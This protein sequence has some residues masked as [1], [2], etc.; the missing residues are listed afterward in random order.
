MLHMI[1]RPAQC[2]SRALSFSRKFALIFL[3]AVVPSL[4]LLALGI[5]EDYQNIQRDE[6]ELAGLR[7]V[8][9]LAPL[10]APAAMHRGLTGRALTGDSFLAPDIGKAEIM[11]DELLQKLAIDI[12]AAF[13][14]LRERTDRLMGKWLLAKAWQGKPPEQNFEA[15]NDFIAEAIEL[16]HFEGG[17]SR[18]LLDPDARGYFQIVTII[19]QLPQLRELVA[20]SRGCIAQINMANSD[21]GVLL[22]RTDARLYRATLVAQ[23]IDSDLALLTQDAPEIA[24]QIGAQW[25][26]VREVIHNVHTAFTAA[27]KEPARISEGKADYF[28]QF[29]LVLDN[30]DKFQASQLK[31]LREDILGRRI[32]SER[33]YVVLKAMLSLM[34]VLV[35]SW[36]IAGFALDITGRVIRL[37]TG[38]ERFGHGDFSIRLGVAGTDELSSVAQGLNRMADDLSEV[39]AAVQSDATELLRASESIGIGSAQVAQSSEEQATAAEAMASA[40]EE[41]T[42]SISQISE[43]AREANDLAEQAGQAAS[44]GGEVIDATVAR[45]RNISTTVDGASESVAQLGGHATQIS[46]I[47]G[48]IKEIADQTNLLALNAAIEAARAGESGRGFAVVADEV[49]K[50]AERTAASTKQITEMITSIQSGSRSAVDNMSR[51]VDEVHAGVGFAEQAGQAIAQIKQTSVQVVDIATAIS[52][53]LR[54]QSATTNDVAGRVENIA[55][56]SEEN[57]SAAASSAGV[58]VQL[59]GMAIGLAQR[60]ATFKFASASSAPSTPAPRQSSY[61]AQATQQLSFEGGTL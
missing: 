35:I 31:I 47:V 52:Q 43:R 59:R 14:S 19:D 32:A 29:T 6:A 53:S 58:A 50:L 5:H 54:E 28:K 27:I 13:P 37:K 41:L 3:L 7:G 1:I 34:L 45:V 10:F 60:V 8:E 48:V 25:Q 55:R 46:G 49:R 33:H 24:G 2:L 16:L 23:R 61:M 38:V 40:V 57:S 36:L 18:L 11:V 20:Q 44:N 21:I 39:L 17:E 15:H 12:P 56:M 30:M 22:G 4:M 51:G 26:I 42:V 9:A